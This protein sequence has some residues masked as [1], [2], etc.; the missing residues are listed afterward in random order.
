MD[1]IFSHTFFALILIFIFAATVRGFSGFG[2][3]LI[4]LPLS[5][6]FVP[7]IK[8]VPVF[9]LID[10]LGN[11]QLLPKV[12][13][14]V[15]WSWVTQVFIPCLLF[16]PIGLL[17]LTSVD[18]QTIILI[19]SGFIFVSAFMIQRGFQYS[20]KSRLA[21]LILGSLAGV[22]NGAASMS[23]PPVG[24]HALASP[25][26]PAVARACLIA[27]FV[28]ADSTAFLSATVAGLV[29]GNTL[30]LTA[31]LLPSSMLG[32]IIG[33]H[34]FETYGAKKFKPV[35]I[36]LLIVIASFS[37]LNVLY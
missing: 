25:F 1:L 12:R 33:T 16:T 15:D 5:A 13:R 3:T 31:A 18:Q 7:V 19:I 29:D 22:M 34:L 24:T 35:T 14:S 30:L 21:P 32:G 37:V 6:L 10:C 17:L 20:K 26:S 11:I 8:L 28:L 9:M 27:F 2:F 36:I 23:G 4:A